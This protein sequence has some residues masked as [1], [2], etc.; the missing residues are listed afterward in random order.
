M[1]RADGSRA[2]GPPAGPAPTTDTEPPRRPRTPPEGLG[3]AAVAERVGKGQT[4]ART[5][6]TS[7]TVLEIVR[8]NVFMFFN[9]LLAAL[10][11]V[12]FLT[13]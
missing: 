4:N 5:V 7:R 9:G 6:R 11:V 10:W 2:G 12:A 13:G 1:T 8:A 3:C